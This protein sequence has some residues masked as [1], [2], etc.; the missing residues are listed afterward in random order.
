MKAPLDFAGMFCHDGANELDG[1]SD[2]QGADCDDC[3]GGIGDGDPGV[4]KSVADGREPAAD[5][6]VAANSGLNYCLRTKTYFLRV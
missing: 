1:V 2:Y 4:I 3:L 6:G 5:A